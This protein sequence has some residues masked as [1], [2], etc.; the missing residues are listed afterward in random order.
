VQEAVKTA[1]VVTASG[2]RAESPVLMKVRMKGKPAAKKY[3]G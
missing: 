3:P 1:V 2:H